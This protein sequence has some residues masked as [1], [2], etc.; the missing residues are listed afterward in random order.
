[1]N[2]IIEKLYTEEPIS[3]E[4]FEM[5]LPNYIILRETYGALAHEYWM[6]LPMSQRKAF[7]TVINAQRDAFEIELKQAYANGFRTGAKLMLEIY[8]QNDGYQPFILLYRA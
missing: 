5:I 4:E 8:F 2:K 6:S 1:M 3:A 7:D